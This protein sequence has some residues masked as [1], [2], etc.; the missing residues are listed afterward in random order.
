MTRTALASIPT[1]VIRL[2]YSLYAVNRVS[3]QTT[4]PTNVP[5]V[6][7][8]QASVICV[9]TYSTEQFSRPAALDTEII[10]SDKAL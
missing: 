7:P 1:P 8:Y 9:F 3:P 5:T 10:L 2:K 6:R 4:Y